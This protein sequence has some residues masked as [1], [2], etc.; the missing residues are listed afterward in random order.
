MGQGLK[1]LSVTEKSERR[2]NDADF[3]EFYS[4]YEGFSR[5]FTKFII[6]FCFRIAVGECQIWCE[7]SRI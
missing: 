3:N 6:E 7:I 1:R 2:A 4:Q 5:V